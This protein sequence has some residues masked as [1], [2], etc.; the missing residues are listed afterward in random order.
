MA[1]VRDGFSEDYN[2][3]EKKNLLY[4]NSQWQVD[5]LQSFQAEL[6]HLVNP[7]DM[8]DEQGNYWKITADLAI[9][10]PVM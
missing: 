1:S 8:K 5:H 3:D 7:K 4:R 10:L 9:Y 6:L 2:E